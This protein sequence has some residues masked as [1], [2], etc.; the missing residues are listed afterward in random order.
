[1]ELDFSEQIRAKYEKA[2]CAKI[3]VCKGG[4]HSPIEEK[5]EPTKHN[6][7]VENEAAK[8]P[9]NAKEE[10]LEPKKHNEMVENE[11]AKKKMDKMGGMDKMC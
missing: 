1:M 4:V 7:M 9:H 5:A 3:G 2:K 6:E 11:A 8:M 10:A